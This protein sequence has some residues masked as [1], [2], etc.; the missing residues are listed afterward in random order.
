MFRSAL[1]PFRPACENLLKI[2]DGVVQNDAQ[3]GERDEDG[4]H[5]RIVSVCFSGFEK[6]AKATAMGADDFDQ[7]GADK[8]ERDRDFERTEE[9]G[10]RLWQGDLAEN[11]KAGRAK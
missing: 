6:R 11:R 2:D 4:E 9:F 7:I 3:K 10:Q 5:Q 1:R 8:C